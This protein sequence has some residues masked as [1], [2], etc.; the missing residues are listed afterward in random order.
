MGQR[1]PSEI[2]PTIGLSLEKT[3]EALTR[4]RNPANAALFKQH[5]LD[6]AQH[7]MLDHIHFYEH[8]QGALQSLRQHGH[9]VSIVSTKLKERIDEALQRDGFSQLVNDVVGGG[10]VTQ[11]KPDPEALLKAMDSSGIPINETIYVG[12]SAADGECANRAGVCFVGVLSGTTGAAELQ[13]WDP[14]ILLKHVGE[15]TSIPPL[16]H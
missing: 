4:N 9:Y 2:E 7:V 15:I 10:C 8:T 12:D 6:H 16:R 1:D 14:A 5:F 11:N 13:R 3:F